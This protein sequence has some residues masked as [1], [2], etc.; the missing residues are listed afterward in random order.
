MIVQHDG[1]G[2]GRRRHALHVD[3]NHGDAVHVIHDPRPLHVPLLGVGL[4]P[5]ADEGEHGRLE[6]AFIV[7]DFHDEP[8]RE[9][10]RLLEV[11]GLD[12][13]TRLDGQVDVA[14]ACRCRAPGSTCTATF[15]YSLGP[16]YG[17][18]WIL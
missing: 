5:E 11:G 9:L 2:L 16:S 14:R 17:S 8:L 12:P 10:Q 18:D 7:E 6:H 4:A 15:G 1:V 13:A 3:A